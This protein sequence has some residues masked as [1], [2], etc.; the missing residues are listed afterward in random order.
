MPFSDVNP[1]K[2]GSLEKITPVWDLGL[3][4][5]GH[6]ESLKLTRLGSDQRQCINLQYLCLIK[7][8]FIPEQ[9][10]ANAR[11][12]EKLCPMDCLKETNQS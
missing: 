11:A 7:L 12:R 4:H 2:E 9:L 5:T 1:L 10:P 3:H 8:E 6:P